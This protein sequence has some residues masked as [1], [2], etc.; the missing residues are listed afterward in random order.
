MNNFNTQKKWRRSFGRIRLQVIIALVLALLITFSVLGIIPSHEQIYQMT[1]SFFD[2]Y[3]P[4]AVA[5]ISFAEN[6]IGVNAY[7]PG[8][9]AILTAMTLTAGK[10][11][12]AIMTFFSI[13]IPSFCA[14]QINYLI[15]RR[16]RRRE[17]GADQEI[18]KDGRYSQNL[19]ANILFMSTMWHPHFAALTSIDAGS[20]KMPYRRFILLF[21]FWF[22]LW[23]IFWGATMY[24]FGIVLS[25]SRESLGYPMIVGFLVIW[26][27]WDF[28]ELGK[29]IREAW[30]A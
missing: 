23:N 24:S 17:D 25:R 11:S 3:G 28:F 4:L 1:G 30:Q 21:G 29:R 14:H 18:N 13:I 27:L 5:P 16:L 2:K 6:I 15:G 8:S 10:P 9:V 20:Q 12:I 26:A 19:T 22:T 7:F